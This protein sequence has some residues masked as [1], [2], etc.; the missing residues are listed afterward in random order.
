[1]F[2]INVQKSCHFR[3]HDF[4]V[5]NRFKAVDQMALHAIPIEDEAVFRGQNTEPWSISG[6]DDA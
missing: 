1:M 3:K 6:Q 5:M 4:F 2:S